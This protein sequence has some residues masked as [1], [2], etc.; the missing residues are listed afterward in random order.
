MT[1]GQKILLHPNW[2]PDAKALLRRQGCDRAVFGYPVGR[3]ENLSPVF[4]Q[5]TV[6]RQSERWQLQ[7]RARAGTKRPAGQLAVQLVEDV[8]NLDCISATVRQQN[9]LRRV[10]SLRSRIVLSLQRVGIEADAIVDRCNLGLADYFE[11]AP[12]S[13]P[14]PMPSALS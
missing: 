12:G 6:V 5:D 8:G 13:H 1:D 14:R 9:R 4:D 3:R 10:A 2:V 7:I 11:Q